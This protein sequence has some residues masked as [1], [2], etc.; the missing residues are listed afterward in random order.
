METNTQKIKPE[1]GDSTSNLIIKIG[2]LIVILLI[3]ILFGCFP[4]IW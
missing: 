2:S 3:T 4:L 1:N